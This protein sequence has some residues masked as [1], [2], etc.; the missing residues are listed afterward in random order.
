MKK[1][2]IML[3]SLALAMPA[4][5]QE[6]QNPNRLLLNDINGA[7]KGYVIDYVKN[8]TF[9][10][11]EGDVLAKL[12]V[13]EVTDEYIMLAVTKTPSCM[14]YKIDIL[15]T[16]IAKQYDD[17][18][19]IKYV[20]GQGS[21]VAT[22]WEDFTD[23]KLTGVELNSD[24]DYTIVTVGIDGYG[25]A[26]GVDRAEIHTPAVPLVGDPQVTAEVV[27]RTL[28]SFSIKFTPNADVLNY[29]CVAGE[30]GSLQ[31]QYEMFAPM[32]GFTSFTQMVM[33][34]GFEC[35]GAE[36]KEWTGMAPNTEYEVFYVA[37]DENQTPAECKCL[38][39]STISLG[40]EGEA[41]VEITPG[42]YTYTDWGGEMKPSQFFTF[43]P[44]DQ[45]S[46]YRFSVITAQ[47]YDADPE[48]YKSDLCSD[49]F[50]PTAYWFFYEP[51]T[52][53][54]QIDPL[55][56][57]VAIAAAKNSLG[58]WG[59]VNELRYTTP[60]EPEG[61]YLEAPARKATGEISGRL[62][63]AKA[64]GAFSHTPGYAPVMPKN[65]KNAKIQLR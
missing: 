22:Y 59:A 65:T 5:S 58:E 19:M 34:W 7:Y 56:E 49:P 52:T 62:N 63:P 10:Y 51:M 28:T 2:T 39:V 44:N 9:A 8:V 46:C 26:A 32:M 13:K 1:F 55:T 54:F 60:E 35:A 17:L 4:F 25:I 3:A 24:T 14:S 15:P 37:I 20:E 18:T 45:A 36:T 41:L 47:N 12:N 11:V 61:D 43:T 48:G 23:A 21:K 53:D 30:K 27:D 31:S 64:N 42:D 6:A 33:S 50:M 29:Y 38:E 40:G 57:V 16:V